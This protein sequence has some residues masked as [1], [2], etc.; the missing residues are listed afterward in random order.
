[1]RHE[2]IKT[3]LETR[4]FCHFQTLKEE[5]GHFCKLCEKEKNCKKDFMNPQCSFETKNKKYVH[6]IEFLINQITNKF[7]K[8]LTAKDF[9]KQMIEII[10]PYLKKLELEQSVCLKIVY[11]TLE[12]GYAPS[13]YVLHYYQKYK[14]NNDKK[15]FYNSIENHLDKLHQEK[16]VWKEY[17]DPFFDLLDKY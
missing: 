10:N 17:H 15:Y 2:Y 12:I 7:K 6:L 5:L 4:Q 13:M 9:F 16:T 1:L 8:R 3:G 14:Q 11:K